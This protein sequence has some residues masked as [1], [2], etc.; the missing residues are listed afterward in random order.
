[1]SLLEDRSWETGKRQIANVCVTNGVKGAELI[2]FWRALN[3]YCHRNM[4]R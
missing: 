3:L 4:T 1:M 2:I